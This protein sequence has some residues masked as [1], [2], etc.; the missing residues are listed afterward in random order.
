MVSEISSKFN[1]FYNF[2]PRI[3]PWEKSAV[4]TELLKAGTNAMLEFRFGGVNLKYSAS[5]SRVCERHGEVSIFIKALGLSGLWGYFVCFS[6][7]LPFNFQ[8]FQRFL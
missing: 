7:L 6:L 8:I 1:Y 4:C 5:S 3:F 2:E